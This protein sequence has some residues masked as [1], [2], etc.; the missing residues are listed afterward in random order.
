MYHY[1]QFL[2]CKEAADCRSTQLPPLA[3]ERAYCRWSR[4]AHRHP[5]NWP[6]DKCR[7]CFYNTKQINTASKY[8]CCVFLVTRPYLENCMFLFCLSW[9][10]SKIYSY[11]QNIIFK[12]PTETRGPRGPW[13]A[14]LRIRSKV[15][16]EP[17][18]ENP[19]GIIW[20]IIFL[21][22]TERKKFS[23]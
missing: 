11:F 17:I 6:P 2:G 1:S 15:K 16:V 10:V 7:K 22:Y 4:S 20:N 18:I 12:G 21:I 14:H 19:R 8:K 3:S 13:V 5:W 9:F 23:Q